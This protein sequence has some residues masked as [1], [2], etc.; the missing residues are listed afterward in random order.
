M[1]LRWGVVI[2]LCLALAACAI[3][4]P[5]NMSEAEWTRLTPQQQLEARE[6][7]AK[8]DQENYRLRMEQ[9]ARLA[10]TRRK[11]QEAESEKIRKLYQDG[12]RIISVIIQDGTMELAGKM[13]PYVIPPFQLALGEVKKIPIYMAENYGGIGYE[14]WVSYQPGALYLDVIPEPDKL[15]LDSYY[16][17]NTRALMENYYTP[18][19]I[20]AEIG[21]WATRN[22]SS[23]YVS[24][25]STLKAVNVNVR[26]TDAT[27]RKA[28]GNG[29]SVD[30][31]RHDDRGISSMHR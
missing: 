27:P 18:P 7:Q 4:Y 14:M 3:R 10:E 9:E 30:V 16:S 12:T 8:F 31:Y 1:E 23:N 21:E 25:R 22:G 28:G 19:K 13:R 29:I 24:W 17:L 15:N 5:L 26:V 2:L 11:A 20:I 6:K